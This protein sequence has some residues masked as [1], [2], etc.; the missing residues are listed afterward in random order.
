MN[1]QHLYDR[2]APFYTPAMRLLPMWL[3][4]AQ[5]TLPWLDEKQAVLEIGPGP[6]VLHEQIAR[7]HLFMVGLDLSLGMLRHTQRRLLRQELTPRLVQANAIV[8]PFADNTF[9]GIVLTFVFSAIPDGS[10][11]LREMQRVLCPDGVLALVD[12]CLPVSGDLVARGLGRMWTLFG[13]V[14]RDEAS[15]MRSV[16]FN[17]VECKEFGAFHSLRMTVA[18]KL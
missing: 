5:C 16:G 13:D 1:Y 6:G 9:D 12:A 3:R 15:L 11:A 10:A 2:V 17:V 4:Y 18:R 14:L 7:S 8:L